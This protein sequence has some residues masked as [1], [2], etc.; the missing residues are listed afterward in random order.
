MK[1]KNLLYETLKKDTR[2]GLDKQE[3]IKLGNWFKK[4]MSKNVVFPNPGYINKF[5]PESF[6]DIEQYKEYAEEHAKKIEKKYKDSNT[7]L[8]TE[9]IYNIKGKFFWYNK[10]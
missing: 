8:P 10:F 9:N 3:L 7:Q 4:K 2:Y 1:L 6:G 5:Y